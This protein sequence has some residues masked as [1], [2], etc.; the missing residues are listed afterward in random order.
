MQLDYEIIYSKRKTLGITVERDSRVIVHAPEG[1]S[2][3]KIEKAVDSK[4]LWLFEKTQHVQKYP[5][6]KQQKEFVTGGTLLYLGRNYRL[7][8]VSDTLPDIEFHAKFII[9]R[10]KQA[11]ARELFQQWYE[12]RAKERL[13]LRSRYFAKAMGVS[14]NR[15]MVSDLKY[16]WGS[17]TPNNNLNFNWRIIKAPSYV[18][19]YLVIHELAHLLESNHTRRFWNIIAVQMPRLQEAREWLKTHGNLLEVDF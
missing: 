10:E 8:I 1:M 18:I 19:D 6:V 7:E 16:R 4:K 15:V 2:A 5:K 12:T 14:F 17:C 13:N 3:E 9:G 11:L